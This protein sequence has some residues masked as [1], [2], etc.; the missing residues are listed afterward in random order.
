MMD[1]ITGCQTSVSGR[2][3]QPQAFLGESNYFGYAF[4]KKSEKNSLRTSGVDKGDDVPVMNYAATSAL[5][6]MRRYGKTSI[7]AQ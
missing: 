6:Q 5:R 4:A 3:W 1:C 2:P 7:T